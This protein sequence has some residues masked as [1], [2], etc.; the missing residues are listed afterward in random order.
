MN[1]KNLYETNKCQYTS[2][3]TNINH[4]TEK[5]TNGIRISV[6]FQLFINENF[7]NNF[8]K[9]NQIAL[10]NN[11]QSPPKSKKKYKQFKINKKTELMKINKIRGL[12]LK[13]SYCYNM[14][15]NC[16]NVQIY[17]AFCD[18][19]CNKKTDFQFPNYI[20]KII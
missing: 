2:F 4:E 16:I 19:L 12:N 8:N 6:V 13:H 18:I 10:N 7:F 9:Y 11:Y 15:S 3:Y 14:D 20:C 1:E 17:D 5:I